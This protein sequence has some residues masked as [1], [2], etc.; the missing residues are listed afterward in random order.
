M[1]G[2]SKRAISGV[3]E[4]QL[5]DQKLSTRHY[6]IDNTV[7]IKLANFDRLR[8]RYHPKPGEAVPVDLQDLPEELITKIL[9]FLENS[10]TCAS[11]APLCHRLAEGWRN[12]K[13][14]CTQLIFPEFIEAV[15]RVALY[16]YKAD[17][18]S[19]TERKLHEVCQLIIASPAGLPKAQAAAQDA[20][21][22][23]LGGSP[24]GDRHARRRGPTLMETAG[25]S[26]HSVLKYKP[27]GSADV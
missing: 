24:L 1:P 6:I 25:L 26:M 16:K 9:E 5:I 15:G 3:I 23:A 14:P 27:D 17:T 12:A 19:T 2:R 10:R 21:A 13:D 7:G 4:P 18:I 22:A 20:A 8:R 11:V